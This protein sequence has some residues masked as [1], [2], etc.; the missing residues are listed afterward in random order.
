MAQ[1]LIRKID[2]DVKENLRLRAKRHGVSM[3]AEAREIL[4]ADLLR[5]ESQA[6]GLGSEIANLFRHIP[7]NEEPF[8]F[9]LKGPVRPANF[10][11]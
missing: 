11:E 6:Y 8:E 1:L 7:D 9:E 2:K 4:R 5:P 3:E 10:D